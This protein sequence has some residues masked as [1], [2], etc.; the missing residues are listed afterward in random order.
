[1]LQK[2]KTFTL[3]LKW[4]ARAAPGFR[5]QTNPPRAGPLLPP[6]PPTRGTTSGR[7]TTA[8]HPARSSPLTASTGC[9]KARPVPGAPLS[10][11]PQVLPDGCWRSA[12]QPRPRASSP[13][14]EGY[15]RVCSPWGRRRSAPPSCNLP[16]PPLLCWE[17]LCSKS[18]CGCPL[19][20]NA[21]LLLQKPP[22]C[23]LPVRQPPPE[24]WSLPWRTCTQSSLEHPEEY[25]EV[26]CCQAFEHWTCFHA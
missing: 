13:R 8:P 14:E 6:P 15:S 18:F 23:P 7:R 16:C 22:E 5:N 26:W 24:V 11:T 2:R 4:W 9:A 19:L 12:W 17:T 10:R 1:M 20:R 25:Q 21:R 3:T